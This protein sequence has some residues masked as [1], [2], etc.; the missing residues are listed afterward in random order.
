MQATIKIA[1]QNPIRRNAGIWGKAGTR[2][3]PKGR[4]PPAEKPGGETKTCRFC[5]GC[6][7]NSNMH[8]ISIGPLIIN[9]RPGSVVHPNSVIV[10][11]KPSTRDSYPWIVSHLVTECVMPSHPTG[12]S[13]DERNEASF[14]VFLCLSAGM[15]SKPFT[16]RICHSAQPF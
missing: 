3:T 16:T 5:L 1:Q 7:V 4:Q 10:P 12:P 2:G 11:S 9:H 13:Q 6:P 15:S 8:L 14:S